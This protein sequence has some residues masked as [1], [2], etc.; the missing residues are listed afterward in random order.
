MSETMNS[1]LRAKKE[2]LLLFEKAF[3]KTIF[4]CLVFPA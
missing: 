3:L 4:R 1:D 2:T